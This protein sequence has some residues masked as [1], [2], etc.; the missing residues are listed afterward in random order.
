MSP[1]PQIRAPP[2][3]NT[4]GKGFLRHERSPA[5]ARALSR[6]PPGTRNRLQT[7]MSERALRRCGNQHIGSVTVLHRGVLVQAECQDRLPEF[8]LFSQPAAAGRPA[9]A[10]TSPSA[11]PAQL[12][13]GISPAGQRIVA[14][15]SMADDP[16]RRECQ[17]LLIDC[18]SC[19]RHR[20]C[21]SRRS[22]RPP[23]PAG[24]ARSARCLPPRAARRAPHPPGAP[25]PPGRPARR[26]RARGSPGRAGAAWRPR[27]RAGPRSPPR[28]GRRPPR[29][30]ARSPPA[31]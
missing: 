17:F 23:G 29:T 27:R 11:L 15:S 22:A 9:P 8:R 1:P 12:S 24:H 4:P 28:S 31:P 16:G 20:Q 2:C 10:A 13:R 6:S 14:G 30:R 19:G 26:A 7:I 3:R 25:G 18:I 21:P 5:M